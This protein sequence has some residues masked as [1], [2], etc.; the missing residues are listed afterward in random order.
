MIEQEELDDDPRPALR[1]GV[2]A[3]KLTGWYKHVDGY[4][5]Y[6]WI[7]VPTKKHS[8]TFDD[9][10][11]REYAKR[12]DN[13]LLQTWPVAGPDRPSS[14]TSTRWRMLPRWLK[15]KMQS[16]TSRSSA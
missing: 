12:L 7:V 10:G 9:E 13:E 14:G 3:K 16:V 2:S 11:V 1:R 6:T 5:G 4:G 8:E 15:R